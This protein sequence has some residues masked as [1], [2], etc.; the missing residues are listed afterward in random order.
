MIG[1]II[2]LLEHG[3][4]VAVVTAAGYPG[5]ARAHE[6]RMAGLLE[7]FA[8]RGVSPAAQ[9]RF[10][11]MGGECNYLLEV[12]PDADPSSSTS[13]AEERDDDGVGAAD[14]Y[15]G[16]PTAD[17]ADGLPMA[18]LRFVDDRLWKT[19][20]MLAWPTH[21]VVAL[22]DSAEAL[23]REHA[24]RLSVQCQVMRKERA[25]G[26][27]PSS[28]VLYEVLEEIAISV[29]LGL[30]AAGFGPGALA[31]LDGLGPTSSGSD[32]GLGGVGVPV[33]RRGERPDA[34]S[35]SDIGMVAPAGLSGAT[36]QPR[37][38]VPFCAFNGGN[39]VF[40]DIGDKSH[41]LTALKRY[42]GA[43][44]ATTLH[45]GDRFTR[46]GNDAATRDVCCIL[47]VACPEET[48][49]FLRLLLDDVVRRETGG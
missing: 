11:V 37:V 33:G 23:L 16:A 38:V 24:A 26:I 30:Q 34:P 35:G 36:S 49:F 6:R 32:M 14:A 41:G 10:L 47:W 4:H 17:A 39:D 21:E 5:D 22:L 42:V 48:S 13:N 25:V 1:L 27:L 31:A 9:R 19:A 20:D 18:R 28:P 8:A 15:Y 3:V 40:V 29:D 44:A 46:S 2:A 43:R 12:D 45:V 7:A